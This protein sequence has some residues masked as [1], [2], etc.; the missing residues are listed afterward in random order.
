MAIE[1]ESR[2]ALAGYD[3]VAAVTLWDKMATV[4]GGISV[5]FLSTHPAPAYRRETLSGLVPE[6][7]RLADRGT[8][9]THPV[10][11]VH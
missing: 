4:G 11:I 2:S 9:Q 10:D 1:Q 5:P 7:R 3:P 8:G 6:M